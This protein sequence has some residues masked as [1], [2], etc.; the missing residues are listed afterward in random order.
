M[1]GYMDICFQGKVIGYFGI[2]LVNNLFLSLKLE[3]NILIS[4]I[5][6]ARKFCIISTTAFICITEHKAGFG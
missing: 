4:H 3:T 5:L 6:I 1:N 2:C